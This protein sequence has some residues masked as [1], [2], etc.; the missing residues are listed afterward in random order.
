MKVDI[1]QMLQETQK[2]LESELVERVRRTAG[3][4]F[5]KM[6]PGRSGS[7][8][9][10]DLRI[11]VAGGGSAT[12]MYSEAAQRSFSTWNFTP[13]LSP[14][15]LPSDLEWPAEVKD[16]ASLFRRMAVAYGLSFDRIALHDNRYPN[17]VAPLSKGPPTEQE[18]YTAPSKDEV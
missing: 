14:L 10:R 6:A 15:P 2:S 17:E 16:K 3:I 8:Q 11:L 1:A 13:E 4:A 7:R 12:P 9:W 18:R 5:E